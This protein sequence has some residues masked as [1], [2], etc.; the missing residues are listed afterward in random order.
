MKH[1]C[2]FHFYYESKLSDRLAC[3]R[4]KGPLLLVYKR[5]P[6]L[7]VKQMEKRYDVI[8]SRVHSQ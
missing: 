1:Y 3:I 2:I 6:A 8:E 5:P 7:V 4:A